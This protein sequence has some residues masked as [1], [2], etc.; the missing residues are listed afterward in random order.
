LQFVLQK[1]FAR[2]LA[3]FDSKFPSIRHFDPSELI[4][5]PMFW[6]CARQRFSQSC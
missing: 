6:T 1:Y 2:H 4:I 5:N 3:I